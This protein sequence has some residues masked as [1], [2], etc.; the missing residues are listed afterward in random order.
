M[1]VTNKVVFRV[2]RKDK[3]DHGTIKEKGGVHWWLGHKFETSIKI[4]KWANKITGLKLARKQHPRQSWL[5]SQQKSP[6]RRAKKNSCNEGL[7]ENN[8]GRPE[9]RR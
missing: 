4:K 3:Y 1:R 2:K 8:K 6:S 9:K 7:A 5:G